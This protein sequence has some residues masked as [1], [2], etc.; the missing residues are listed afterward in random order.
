MSA[1]CIEKQHD[2]NKQLIFNPNIY[3]YL[4]IVYSS[5]VKESH[6]DFHLDYIYFTS[7]TIPWLVYLMKYF[8][9]TI[10][11]LKVRQF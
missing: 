2:Q 8:K 10:S 1:E 7:I 9:I 6:M 11:M 4:K 3:K 5:H